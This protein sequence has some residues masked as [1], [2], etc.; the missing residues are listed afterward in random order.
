MNQIVCHIAMPVCV[1]NTK[2]PPPGPF[3]IHTHTLR[4]KIILLRMHFIPIPP[5]H[6]LPKFVSRLVFVT[7]SSTGLE[8]NEPLRSSLVQ[9]TKA[10]LPTPDRI[11][12]LDNV[13]GTAISAAVLDSSHH[14]GGEADGR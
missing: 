14:S 8:L 5:F 7:S 3:T 13:P 4:K 6:L 1:R 10:T 11:A 9:N 12:T 2:S